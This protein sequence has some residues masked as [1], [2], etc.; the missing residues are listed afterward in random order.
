VVPF[1][2]SDVDVHGW[3]VARLLL[4]TMLSPM[5]AGIVIA[6]VWPG[7]ADLLARIAEN[8]AEQTL[9]ALFALRRYQI[10]PAGQAVLQ[11]YNAIVQRHGPKM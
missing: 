2:L 3:A 11:K 6:S 10:T 1:L 7:K 8:I 5:I 4:G 9:A